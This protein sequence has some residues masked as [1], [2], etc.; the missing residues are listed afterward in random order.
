MRPAVARRL[1][2]GYRQEV[3]VEREAARQEYVTAP[4]PRSTSAARCVAIAPIVKVPSVA[5]APALLLASVHL[6]PRFHSDRARQRV[7]GARA[8]NTKVCRCRRQC[9]GRRNRHVP[10]CVSRIRPAPVPIAEAPEISG[11]RRPARNATWTAR[12]VAVTTASVSKRDSTRSVCHG[13]DGLGVLLP[14]GAF[15]ALSLSRPVNHRERPGREREARSR[16]AR[17]RTRVA[18]GVRHADRVDRS[19]AARQESRVGCRRRRDRPTPT[20]AS[21]TVTV[22]AATSCEPS[23]VPDVGATI[24]ACSGI[25]EERVCRARARVRR[26]CRPAG[27]DLR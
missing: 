11:G 22:S 25:D 13:G 20:E 7:R 24:S 27:A 19:R 5:A 3:D 17:R 6:A 21:T 18:S 15:P 12:P 16:R 26:R 9:A 1:P 4:S 2:L 10:P 8:E 14:V 23:V